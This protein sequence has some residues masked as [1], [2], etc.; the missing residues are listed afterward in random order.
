[1]TTSE[2]TLEQEIT[3]TLGLLDDNAFL[4]VDGLYRIL[5][6][7]GTTSE[8][9]EGLVEGIGDALYHCQKDMLRKPKKAKSNAQNLLLTLDALC[10]LANIN[11]DE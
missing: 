8:Q 11:L 7:H 1:M 10:A 6:N 9:L 3:R 4:L 5:G 2:H